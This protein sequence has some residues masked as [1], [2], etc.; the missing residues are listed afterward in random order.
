MGP[1]GNSGIPGAFLGL[2]AFVLL[3]FLFW[4]LGRAERPKESRY[5]FAAGAAVVTP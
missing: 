4:A 3:G 5:L 2:G 1:S